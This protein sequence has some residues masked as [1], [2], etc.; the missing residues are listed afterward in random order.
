MDRNTLL[1]FLLISLVLIFTPKY[2]ELVSPTVEV[3]PSSDTTSVELTSSADR[4]RYLE[5][6]YSDPKEKPTLKKL[7]IISWDKEK[8]EIKNDEET[9]LIETALYSANI[10][11]I[12]GGTLKSFFTK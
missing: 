8:E 11:S 5:K 4:N 9:V 3:G 6:G 7:E 10:S 12:N 2:M 1:A